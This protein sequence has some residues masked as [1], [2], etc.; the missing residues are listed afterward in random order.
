[1]KPEAEVSLC[2]TAASAEALPLT[3]HVK[4][5]NTLKELGYAERL[6]GL[7]DSIRKAARFTNGGLRITNSVP[8]KMSVSQLTTF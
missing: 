5:R 2:H 3:H 4:A 7:E 8:S 1:M 6:K